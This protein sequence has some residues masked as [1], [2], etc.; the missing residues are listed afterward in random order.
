[1]LKPFLYILL[2]SMIACCGV[3][4]SAGQYADYVVEHK[5]ELMVSGNQQSI[6]YQLTYVPIEQLYANALLEGSDPKE[7]RE[8]KKTD[9]TRPGT[10]FS[11]MID[12]GSGTLFSRNSENA[13]VQMKY[14]ALEFKN[15]IKAITT[16]KDTI[17]CQGFIFQANAGFGNKSYF[18]FDFPGSIT[19][20]KKV[21]LHS[22]YLS[23]SIVELDLSPLHK[24]YPE[25]IIK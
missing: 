4:L 20:L 6:Q 11:L 5:S 23:D 10:S 15:S 13:S 25:L 7:L 22:I 3:R 24:N 9:K 2:I 19:N 21:I 1:M 16:K 14:Y 8:L 18:N 17:D 12:V